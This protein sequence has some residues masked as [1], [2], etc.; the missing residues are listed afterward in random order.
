METVKIFLDKE[1]VQQRMSLPVAETNGAAC[2]DIRSKKNAIL[3]PGE[4]TIIET[5][6]YIA[7]P[8]S[9]KMNIVPRSGLA[10]KYGVTVINSPGI[11]DPDYRGEIKVI[12]TS[13][14][15]HVVMSGE[16]IAQIYLEKV[17]PFVWEPVENI[18]DLGVTERGA[19]GLG[20]TGS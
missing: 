14:K 6:M 8:E 7:V 9:H 13:L 16:R 5:G 18:E 17:I 12:L 19:K 2:V 3:Q 15:K 11:I 4:I 1:F 20:S 10:A